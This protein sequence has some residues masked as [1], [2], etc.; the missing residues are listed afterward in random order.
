MR[1]A[2]EKYRLQQNHLTNQL[3]QCGIHQQHYQT[4]E[5]VPN[6]LPLV[7]RVISQYG[8]KIV[9]NLINGHWAIDKV[10][11]M[12]PAHT[13]KIRVNDATKTSEFS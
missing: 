10:Q 8:E 7:D 9:D 1:R 2:L 11:R 6:N 13:M 12:R 3:K 5:A 4:T